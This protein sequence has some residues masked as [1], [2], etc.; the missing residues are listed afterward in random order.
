MITLDRSF[1]I[2]S[3]IPEAVHIGPG[4]PARNTQSQWPYMLQSPAYTHTLDSF[5]V[6]LHSANGGQ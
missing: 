6:S 4:G 1:L 5:T 3:S 2:N